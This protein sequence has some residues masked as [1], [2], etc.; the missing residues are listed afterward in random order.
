MTV[1][2]R[3]LLHVFPTFA[4][5]GVPVRIAE[6]LNRLGHRDRHTI[7]AL[8]GVTDCRS[9]LEP[10]LAVAVAAAPIPKGNLPAALIAIRRELGRHRPDLLLTYNWGAI[11]WGLANRLGR[12]V[13]HLH[14][15]SGFGP[16][17]ADG[18]LFRRS[19]FRRLALRRAAAL[20][21]PSATL[22]TIAT[23]VWMIDPARIRHIPNGVDV[24]R[25]AAAPD[26][27]ALPDLGRAAGGR[28]V[29]TLAPLRA[30]KNVGR[31]LH[32]FAALPPDANLRLVVV[33][34]G[35][36][37][38]GLERLAASLG[39]AGRTHFAGHCETPEKVLGLIDVF[40]ISSD[41]EQMPNTLLQAMAA[42]RAVAAV[43]VGDVKAILAPENRPFVA[44]KGDTDGLARAIAALLADEG[45]RARLGRANAAHVAAHYDQARMVEAYRELYDA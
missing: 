28:I 23:D 31:L 44:A 37:R 42:G 8:D 30:E 10:G 25:F 3:H 39:I 14:F 33:G 15:E 9:R 22:V 36:E 41:T 5:G 11:E 19:L 27:A 13:R 38:A 16:E 32:A 18:Q 4:V 24:A 29:G 45:L 43:D 26:P 7:L 40:A 17:E 12:G 20:V 21:V 35:A 34:D 1:A 6:V 2:P